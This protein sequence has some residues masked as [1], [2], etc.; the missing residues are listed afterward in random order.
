MIVKQKLTGQKDNSNLLFLIYLIYIKNN[1]KTNEK[2]GH[3]VEVYCIVFHF[4]AF[5]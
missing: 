1:N 3:C 4:V 2:S 5:H